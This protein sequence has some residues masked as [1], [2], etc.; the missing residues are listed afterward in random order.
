MPVFKDAKFSQSYGEKIIKNSSID[1][2]A[3][4]KVMESAVYELMK[5]AQNE[6]WTPEELLN[7]I[8]DLFNNDGIEAK[9]KSQNLEKQLET[10]N[11]TLR[12]FL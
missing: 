8:D 4:Y 3:Y 1:L 2:I 10:V 11:N 7:K 6:G 9:P 12:R 5:K